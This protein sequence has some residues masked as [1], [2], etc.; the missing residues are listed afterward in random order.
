MAT[1]HI[2]EDLESVL[3]VGS[4][5]AQMARI[6]R[7]STTCVDFLEDQLE[8]GRKETKKLGFDIETHK[9][10]VDNMPFLN[11][12]NYNLATA[13]NILNLVPLGR[14]SNA[15][16]EIKRVLVDGGYTMCVFPPSA[17]DRVEGDTTITDG[18]IRD[19]AI[20]GFDVHEKLTGRYRV[21]V[22][23]DRNQNPINSDMRPFLLVGRKIREGTITPDMFELLNDYS[24][25]K[26][27]KKEKKSDKLTDVEPTERSE[28][29]IGFKNLDTGLELMADQEEQR[30]LIETKR[31]LDEAIASGKV[32]KDDI[33]S[34]IEQMMSGGSE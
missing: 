2:D 30:T 24:Y 7:R 12:N 23:E 13:S 28:L 20:A 27:V 31:R 4:G 33:K 11:N 17:F 26:G 1:G 9:S 21:S 10:L 19:F 16:S 22:A 32:S 15:V 25:S 6:L 3:E 18:L 14:R 34:I 29:C 5:P 8:N